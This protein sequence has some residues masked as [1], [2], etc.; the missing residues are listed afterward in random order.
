[1]VLWYHT[2]LF[3]LC[4]LQVLTY[5]ASLSQNGC[6]TSTY[7][8]YI[9]GRKMMKKQTLTHLFLISEKPNF[10]ESSPPQDTFTYSSVTS[11]SQTYPVSKKAWN[12]CSH[13]S[14]IYETGRPGRKKVETDVEL[15]SQQ[16]RPKGRKP[17]S[18]SKSSECKLLLQFNKLSQYFSF[19]VHI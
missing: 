17:I 5:I 15:S 9:Q 6:C 1:M 19:L 14:Y 2:S 3:P 13:F 8:I 4:Y 16:C 11:E 7:H 18:I 12:L 10:S